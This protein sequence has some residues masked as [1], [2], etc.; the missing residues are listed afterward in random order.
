VHQRARQVHQPAAPQNAI[1]NLQN[2]QAHRVAARRF[3]V[4][5]EALRLQ[6]L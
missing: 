1:G 6:R 5:D 2:M 4:T 3:V